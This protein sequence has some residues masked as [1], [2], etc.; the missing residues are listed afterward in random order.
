MSLLQKKRLF[1]LFYFLSLLIMAFVIPYTLLKNVA[2][3]HGS[4]L[5]WC[6]FALA[7]IWG[8]ERITSRWKD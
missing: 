4:F 1:W 5:F 8:V 3:F 2:S 6:I 7:A